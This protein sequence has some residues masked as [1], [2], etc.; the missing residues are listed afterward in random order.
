MLLNIS[1][2]SVHPIVLFV[3]LKWLDNLYDAWPVVYKRYKIRML[4]VMVH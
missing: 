4:K 2:D 1:F 3:C